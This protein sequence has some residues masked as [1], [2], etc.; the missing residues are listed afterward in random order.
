MF[1]LVLS[2]AAFLALLLALGCKSR[3]LG[4]YVSPRISGQV[5]D[6]DTQQPLAGVKVTRGPSKTGTTGSS[7]KGGE[8]L[9]RKTPVQTDDEGRFV[10]AS[11]RVLS[12]VRGA[13]WNLI[14]LS[15]DRAGCAHFQTNFPAGAA[16]NSDGGEPRLDVGRIM[17]R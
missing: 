14:S 16:S 12:I 3:P 5:L 10:L 15:F 8:L 11:E 6:A 1:R 4:P 17:L 2:I 13:N 9:M 7:P